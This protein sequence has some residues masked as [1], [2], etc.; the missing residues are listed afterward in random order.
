MRYHHILVDD[1]KV[2][3]C[4]NVNLQELLDAAPAWTNKYG[5][6]WSTEKCMVFYKDG[7]E[8]TFKYVLDGS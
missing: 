5:M 2:K 4:K 8:G 3:A 1:A 6:L 7:R